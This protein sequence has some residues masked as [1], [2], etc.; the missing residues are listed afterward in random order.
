M[1][2]AICDASNPK[3]C[4]PRFLDVDSTKGGFAGEYERLEWMAKFVESFEF[5]DDGIS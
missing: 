4:L 2:T 1:S 5:G 3:R